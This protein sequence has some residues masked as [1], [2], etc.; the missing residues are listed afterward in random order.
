M[1]DDLFEFSHLKLVVIILAALGLGFLLLQVRT[2]PVTRVSSWGGASVPAQ[3]NA[4]PQAITGAAA[5]LIG[6]GQPAALG[7][8][9]GNPLNAAN[10]IMT[11]GYGVGTHAPASIWGGVDIALDGNGD[12]AADPEGT[13]GA[14]IY[15]TVTGVVRVSRDTWPAG[16][17]LAIENDLYKVG[18][19]HLS[20]YAVQDGQ[21]VERGQLIGYVGSTGMSSGPHLHYEV[22]KEG[23]NVNPLDYGAMDGGL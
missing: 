23:V 20:E 12:G 15:A 14:P 5:P 6:R 17:Y 18:Y 10:V 4:G 7:V 16:N 2:E 21:Q 11:Q 22:W 9:A 1:L 8:P 13:M 3:E 19:A